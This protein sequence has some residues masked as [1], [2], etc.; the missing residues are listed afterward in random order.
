MNTSWICVAYSA[1]VAAATA[2][3]L[4]Y[5]IG[6]GSF[7]DGKRLAISYKS[8]LNKGKSQIPSTRNLGPSSRDPEPQPLSKVL[9]LTRVEG[10]V[11]AS[12]KVLA[13]LSSRV[14]RDN[15]LRNS[16]LNIP[17]ETLQYKPNTDD[18]TVVVDPT[19]RASVPGVYIMHNPVT[20]KY[21]VGESQNIYER[22][23]RHCSELRNNRHPNLQMLKEFESFGLQFQFYFYPVEAVSGRNARVSYESEIQRMV[24]L[25]NSNALYNLKVE[26]PSQEFAVQRSGGAKSVLRKEPGV[27]QVYCEPTGKVYYCQSKNLS[28][29]GTQIRNKLK[30]QATLNTALIND[31]VTHGEENFT[32]SIVVSGADYSSEEVR[33]QIVKNL[34]NQVG[35]E[36]TYNTGDRANKEKAVQKRNPDGTVTVY[37]SVSEASRQENMNIKTLRK[38]AQN[39]VDGFSFLSEDS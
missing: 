30:R 21:W 36:N 16:T 35:L 17:F 10:L 6:Q 38:K 18:I 3:F 22:I 7:S 11:E 26:D 27:L 4:I 37:A 32:F 24:C 12:P 8:G 29:K 34:V 25:K 23:R 31:W 2:V 1:P 20:G 9:G 13:S 5:P 15:P 28:Q 19:G 33:E 39:N 14:I